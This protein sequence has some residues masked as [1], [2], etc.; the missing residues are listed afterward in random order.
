MIKSGTLLPATCK[1]DKSF[2]YITISLMLG[3]ANY[4]GGTLVHICM[5][6]LLIQRKDIAV[7]VFLVSYFIRVSQTLSGPNLLDQSNTILFTVMILLTFIRCVIAFLQRNFT[8]DFTC[9]LF[10]AFCAFCMLGIILNSQY[11]FLCFSKLLLFG[12]FFYALRFS[13]FHGTTQKLLHFLYN[14]GCSVSLVSLF[15][16]FVPSIGYQ[17][18]GRSFQGF[19]NHPQLAAVV[20]SFFCIFFFSLL[21]YQEGK[22][23]LYSLLFFIINLFLIYL[24]NS[25][26]GMF[27][28]IF[29]IPLMI[30]YSC[31]VSSNSKIKRIGKI[32]GSAILLIVAF[33]VVYYQEEV[34]TFIFKET[35]KQVLYKDMDSLTASRQNL[36]NV[37]M[38]NF[39]RHPII[40]NGFRTPNE[41]KELELQ[42]LPGTKI[43]ISA[44]TEKGN[45]ISA[46]LEETGI[47]G[48]LITICII[49]SFGIF[50]IKEHKLLVLPI[51]VVL[52]IANFGEF[53]MFAVNGSGILFWTSCMIGTDRIYSNYKINSN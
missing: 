2:I 1:L 23:M 16:A 53:F 46:I 29:V 35:R 43:V 18:N 20:F 25:R 41:S 21:F 6:L 17:L 31:L 39:Y 45:F 38:V 22:S 12:V 24:S 5:L 26:T 51:L 19:F 10:N 4:A 8:F 28:V 42:Y 47:I 7:A 11:S 36:T 9:K 52:I 48:F 32:Y 33:I 3:F 40:G 34:S 49:L 27:S 50:K 37:S 15:F 14:C 13:F 30:A 44:P